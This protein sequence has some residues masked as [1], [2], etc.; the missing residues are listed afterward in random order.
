VERQPGC[1]DDRFGGASSEQREE[2][3]GAALVLA[4]VFSSLLLVLGLLFVLAAEDEGR[5]ARNQVRGTQALYAAEAAARCV[6]DWLERPD[7]AS[8]FLVPSVSQVNRSLRRVDPEGDGSTV[9]WSAAAAPWNVTYR[10]GR[11]DLFDRPYQGS[12]ALSFEGTEDGP[13][14]RIS[15]DGSAGERACLEAMSDAL[16]PG[17]P[18]DRER[19]RVAR[20]DVFSPPVHSIAGQRTR[21]GLATVQVTVLLVRDTPA[22]EKDVASRTVRFVVAALPYR[23]LRGP[24]AAVGDI[25]LRSGLEAKW[26]PVTAGGSILLPATD[27]PAVPSGWPRREGFRQLVPDAD[28]DGTDEDTDADGTR[29]WD[30]WWTDP[31]D[32]LDDPWFAAFARGTLDPAPPPP[33]TDDQPW[34]FDPAAVP[35]GP[36][37]LWRPDTDRSTLLQS[38]SGPLIPDPGYALWKMAAQEGGAARAYYAFDPAAGAWRQAGTGPPVTVDEATRGR[39]GLFFFDT[40]DGQAPLD[41]N[42]DGTADNLAPDVVLGPGWWASGTLFVGA[43]AL[44]LTGISGA[45]LTRVIHLPGEPCADRDGDG[46]CGPAEPFLRLAYPVDPLAPGASFGRV[47]LLQPAPGAERLE[48]GPPFP[49]PLAFEGLLLVAGDVRP[50]GDAIFQGAVVAGGSFRPG[51]SPPVGVLTV[52]ADP[53]LETGE[54]PAAES[55]APRTVMLSWET[56][57]RTS[58]M[59]AP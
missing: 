50:G 30:E 13:D 21:F 10:H 19:A 3:C 2:Q 9:L 42:G 5:M 23:G 34:P 43:A 8:G 22:G 56:E 52:L 32:T 15:R 41:T 54:A 59:P 18:S 49:A 35:T 1:P 20:I 48:R 39:A 4:V 12:P 55:G 53:L 14:I 27:S 46:A 31:D 24:L 29:D 28:S 6:R 26:G 51:A 45:G 25:D 16:L 44:R 33:Q 37:G 58:P 47:A 17:F 36:S 38:A 40:L 11:D 57:M 7:P